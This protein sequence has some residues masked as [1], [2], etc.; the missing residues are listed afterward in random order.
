[1]ASLQP[2]ANVSITRENPLLNDL[3]VGFGWN[4]IQGSGPQ[5]QIV[6]A[7]I[8]VGEN[9]HALSDEHFLFFNQ[10]STTDGAVQYVEG[11]EDNDQIEITLSTVP[12]NV[13]KMVFLLYV[14]PEVRNPGNFGAVRHAHMRIMDRTLSELVRFELPQSSSEINAVLM[15]EIYRRN[16]EWKFR[17]VG[18]GY[19]GG[20]VQV[21][22]DFKVSL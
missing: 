19:A 18:Q 17:A 16:T 22:N 9:G 7:V 11:N 12:E 1:M 13:S 6:P 4:T 5:L 14:D 20:I 2:G 10:L 8:L 15:G 21:A 3:V